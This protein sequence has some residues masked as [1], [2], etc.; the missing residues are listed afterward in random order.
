MLWTAMFMLAIG[1]AAAHAG[2]GAQAHDGHG[3]SG[4][5]GAACEA[6]PSA[7]PAPTCVDHC[8]ASG[9]IDAPFAAPAAAM[10][11]VALLASFL[12]VRTPERTAPRGRPM[13][14]M[15][16]LLLERHAVTVMRN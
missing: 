7:A 11:V 3:S 5:H 6:D 10:F 15:R 12:S 9:G 16:Q 14:V 4:C 2:M 8:L 1:P 13:A